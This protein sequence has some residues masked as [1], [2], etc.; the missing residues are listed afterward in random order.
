MLGNA[1]A[2]EALNESSLPMDHLP[3]YVW[4]ADRAIAAVTQGHRDD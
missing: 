2:H 3:R 4:L 1:E